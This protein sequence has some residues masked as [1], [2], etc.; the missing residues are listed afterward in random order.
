MRW[1][2]QVESS[3][4]GKEEYYNFSSFINKGFVVLCTHQPLSFDLD[5]YQHSKIEFERVPF[6]TYDFKKWQVV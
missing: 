1:Y 3:I 6:A 2:A 5:Y 4:L